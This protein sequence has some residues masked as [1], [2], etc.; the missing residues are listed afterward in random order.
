MCKA[1]VVLV[2]IGALIAEFAARQALGMCKAQVV[3]G[4]AGAG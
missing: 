3:L 1:Q 2:A 4:R